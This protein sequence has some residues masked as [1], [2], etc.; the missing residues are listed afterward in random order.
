[1]IFLRKIIFFVSDGAC[2]LPTKAGDNQIEINEHTDI[3]AKTLTG[4]QTML[5][6]WH[7][8]RKN[9]FCIKSKTP[10]SYSNKKSTPECAFLFFT[11]LLLDTEFL[12]N[13]LGKSVL[14]DNDI[15]SLVTCECL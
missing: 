3:E 7:C 10:L 11:C 1:M 6:H 8:Q 2:L 4:L 12:A 9:I 14:V 15:H 13:I 5:F